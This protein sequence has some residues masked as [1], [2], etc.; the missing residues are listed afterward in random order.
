MPGRNGNK[1]SKA[2]GRTS[3]RMGWHRR[4]LHFG[5]RGMRKCS[6]ILAYPSIL[7]DREGIYEK[8]QHG[9]HVETR[10]GPC[11]YVGDDPVD[12]LG[13]RRILGPRGVRI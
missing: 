8:Q 11:G 7:E 1:E 2:T 9:S 3:E 13:L 10:V 5:P 6:A 12:P 4:I